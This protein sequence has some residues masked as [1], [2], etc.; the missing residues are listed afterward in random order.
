MKSNAFINYES[1]QLELRYIRLILF[2]LSQNVI[3]I[4][5]QETICRTFDS[6][7]RLFGHYFNINSKQYKNHD[8]IDF[9]RRW[10]GMELGNS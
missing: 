8:F 9:Y 3:I 4:I 1:N 10:N 7:I 6:F 2:L 5:E